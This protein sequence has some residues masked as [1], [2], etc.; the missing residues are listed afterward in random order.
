MDGPFGGG[1]GGCVGGIVGGILVVL[2]LAEPVPRLVGPLDTWIRLEKY[3]LDI[4][5]GIS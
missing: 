5:F 3:Q 4:H 2:D 1:R